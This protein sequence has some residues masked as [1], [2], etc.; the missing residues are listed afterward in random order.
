MDIS[1]NKDKF[2]YPLA[3]LTVQQKNVFVYFYHPGRKKHS[4]AP[5]MK[6]FLLQEPNRHMFGR[7]EQT[8]IYLHSCSNVVW[9]LNPQTFWKNIIR[10]H[11]ITTRFQVQK[12]MLKWLYASGPINFQK[13]HGNMYVSIISEMS[14]W[15]YHAK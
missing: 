3:I 8:L 1:R 9:E 5:F 12:K 6:M 13:S 2:L 10:E 4:S 15:S 11:E 14:T 7:Y